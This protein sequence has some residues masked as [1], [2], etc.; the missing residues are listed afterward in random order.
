MMSTM[1]ARSKSRRKDPNLG[2]SPRHAGWRRVG[3]LYE[4]IAPTLRSPCAF[5]PALCTFASTA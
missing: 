3:L 5:A 1:A 2:L 4:F